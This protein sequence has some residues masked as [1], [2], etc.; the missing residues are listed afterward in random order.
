ML[1]QVGAFERDP[2]KIAGILASWLGPEKAE[3]DAMAARAK[4][5]GAQ[6]QNALF[7]IVE[8]LAAMIKEE[9]SPH[10]T[11]EHARKHSWELGA[12]WQGSS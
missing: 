2:A 9:R 12:A 1:I 4:A 11:A 6:W 10:A 7:R 5:I 3:F 8:D